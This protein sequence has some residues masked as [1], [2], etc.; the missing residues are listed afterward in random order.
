VARAVGSTA[1]ALNIAHHAS[2]SAAQSRIPIQ[3]GETLMA[4]AYL[5]RDEA[6][7]VI[8]Y[9]NFQLKFATYALTIGFVAGD[10]TA[11]QNDYA[12]LAYTINLAAVF[13][14]EAKERVQY[15]DT[16]LDGPLGIVTPAAPTIPTIAPPAVIPPPGILPR[17]SAIVQRIKAHPNYTEAMGQDMGIVGATPKPPANP[18][19]TATAEAQPNSEILLKWVK[20]AFDGVHI[21][22]QRAGETTWTLIGMDTSSPYRDSRAPLVAG[23]PEVRRYRLRYF[24]NDTPLGDYSDIMTVTTIP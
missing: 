24:K 2:Q 9:N 21:E 22:S 11:V 16:F 14:E 4:N 19:P 13:K 7:Q 10:V 20:G 17:L 15:K 23:Q 12:M 8:W 6:G 1:H 3:Q 5:P 18:K